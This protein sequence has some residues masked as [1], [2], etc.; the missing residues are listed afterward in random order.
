MTTTYRAM[1]F[2]SDARHC[3]IADCWRRLTEADRAD[4]IKAARP[5]AWMSRRETC[6]SFTPIKAQP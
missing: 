1:I 3:A 6:S 5:I 2:C 4:A